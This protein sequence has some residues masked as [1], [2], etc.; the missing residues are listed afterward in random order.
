MGRREF[1]NF[2]NARFSPL[3]Q[4][5]ERCLPGQACKPFFRPMKGNLRFYLDSFSVELG[6]RILIVIGIQEKCDVSLPWWHYFWMTTKPTTTTTATARRSAKNDMFILT[7]N[8]F[9]RAS[10]WFLHFFVVVAALWYESSKFH[11]PALWS[12]W[13][14][15]KTCRFLFLNLDN[16][17]YGPKENF[18]KICQISL[19]FIRLLRV[20]FVITT[21][22]NRMKFRLLPN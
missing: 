4:T 13:T 11:E 16:N 7:N 18:A 9:A 10:R 17:R 20:V 15:H 19:K 3:T 14:Q 8:N 2:S 5:R 22:S 6:F 12:R 21:R 1:R